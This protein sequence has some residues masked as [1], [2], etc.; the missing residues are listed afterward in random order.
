[1]NRVIIDFLT[2]S[3]RVDSK[4][5]VDFKGNLNFDYVCD[6]LRIPTSEFSNMGRIKYYK[7]RYECNNISVS[8]PFDGREN[9]QGYNISMSGNGCRFY[10]TYIKQDEMIDVYD[11]WRNLFSR[12]RALTNEGLSINVSRIDIAVDD[13]SGALDINRI[14]NCIDRDE[15]ATR[16]QKKV[17]FR[18][19]CDMYIA[20]S[21]VKTSFFR[22]I[23]SSTVEF[24]SRQS[25]SFCRIYDKKAEQMQ[26]NYNDKTEFARLEAIPHWVRLEV[27]FK[28]ENAIKIVNAFIEQAF[29][30]HFFAGY[31]N[32]MLRFVDRDDSNIS[33]CTTQKWW[34][35]FIGTTHKTSM[36]CG[37][38]KPVTRKR[39]LEYVHKNLFGSIY[40]AINLEGLDDFLFKVINAANE[41][42]SQKHRK[43][44]SG[45]EWNIDKLCDSSIWQFLR[46]SP[47]TESSTADEYR[48]TRRKYSAEELSY[49]GLLAGC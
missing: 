26:K 44:C 45:L 6:F 25:R 43:L 27:E 19:N 3:I 7:E 23:R 39:H 31:I 37:D 48:Y 49:A 33:R 46:P 2:F 18:G 41:K 32:S 38:Y 42:L 20:Q 12:L 28:D 40:T 29:F 14:I 4:S 8:V 15:V 34:Q 24:G 13:F 10:E 47:E 36:A 21:A 22:R 17:P 11:I 9:S 30:P 16:F 35:E 1:M 5:P